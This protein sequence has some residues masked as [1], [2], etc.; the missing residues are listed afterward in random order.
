M[1]CCVTVILKG[2]YNFYTVFSVYYT[3]S[4]KSFEIKNGLKIQQMGN[5]LRDV[6]LQ[7]GRLKVQLF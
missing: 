3:N 2:T 7:T 1:H 5:F 6:G 4:N